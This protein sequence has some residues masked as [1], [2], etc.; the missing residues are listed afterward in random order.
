MP[1]TLTNIFSNFILVNVRIH[2]RNTEFVTLLSEP[3]ESHFRELILYYK[4]KGTQLQRH[5]SAM[6]SLLQASSG[7]V[8]WLVDSG[9]N[10]DAL[11]AAESQ[12]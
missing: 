8:P 12:H 4:L 10:V 5:L 6:P 9:T 7:S 11:S 2:T 1:R 3:E